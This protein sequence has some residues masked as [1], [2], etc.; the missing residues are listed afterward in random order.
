LTRVY[1]HRLEAAKDV[2]VG[3]V[4]QILDRNAGIAKDFKIYNF[5]SDFGIVTATFPYTRGITYQCQVG[6]QGWPAYTAYLNG[7]F[8]LHVL[9]GTRRDLIIQ[10]K[11]EWE[12]MQPPPKLVCTSGAD[13]ELFV[14]DENN[15]VIPAWMFLGSK[16]KPSLARG[17][18]NVYWDGFQVEF[19]VA[20]NNCLAWM[21]DSVHRGLVGV[22]DHAKKFNPK[23]KLSTATVM[24]V[25]PEILSSAAE[26]HVQFGC[27]PS[28]NVYG[29]H[30]RNQ[31]GRETPF[32]FVGGHIHFGLYDNGTAK[33][34]TPSPEVTA[35]IIR[36]MDSIVGV[37]CVSLFE[38]YDS[39]I[40]RQFYGLAGEYRTP[41]YGIEYRTLS[42]AWLTHPFIANMVI[43]L[44]RMS[45]SYGE[46]N[47]EGWI[48]TED[49]V[50]EAIQTCNVDM[51]RRILDRNKKY[52]AQILNQCYGINYI[53]E[54][55]I[56]ASYYSKKIS[57]LVESPDDIEKNWYLNRPG[58]W[59]THCDRPG[60]NVSSGHFNYLKE[61]K[62]VE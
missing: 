59:K 21:L 49:E 6:T 35:R 22:Y 5:K 40:R 52:L 38:D 45:A 55:E 46:K 14:V 26:E 57:D 24:P 37:A 28:M 48:A 29:L 27:M 25:S 56:I 2:K 61:G 41:S 47:L 7:D 19:D 50:I 9:N 62:K 39:P 44:A 31:S 15:S 51:A 18:N 23:A 20:A 36:A 60:G 11:Y 13:P 8:Q 1:K 17:G 54:S 12:S 16:T 32:R 33:Y 10:K 43:D 58:S 30:G 34:K 53:S 3:D 4:I 42:N